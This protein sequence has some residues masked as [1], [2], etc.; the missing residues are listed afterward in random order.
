MWPHWQA[1]FASMKERIDLQNTVQKRVCTK[2]H[3]HEKK[4]LNTMMEYLQFW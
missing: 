2:F 1:A 4:V 3:F